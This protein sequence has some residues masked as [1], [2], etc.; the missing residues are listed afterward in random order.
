LRDSTFTTL[1]NDLLAN[2]DT[3]ERFLKFGAVEGLDKLVLKVPNDSYD[4]SSMG[5]YTDVLKKTITNGFII[6]IRNSQ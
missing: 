6:L 2:K 5:Q 4:T 3:I 1:E